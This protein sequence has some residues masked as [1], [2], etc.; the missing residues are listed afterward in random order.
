MEVSLVLN[1]SKEDFF[2]FLYS[3]IIK[4]IKESTGRMLS[5]KKVVKGYTYEKNVKNHKGKLINM[6]ILIA[7]LDP[8][9]EYMAEIET[10]QGKNIMSYSIKHLEAEKINVTYKEEYI[11][12]STF[13]KLKF[14]VLN[15][16]HEKSLISEA[17]SNLIDIET[18]IKN[19]KA[20]M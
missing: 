19:S 16:M 11:A 10:K 5:K 18:Y 17:K 6:K 4:D 7:E 15:L 13:K 2:E 20:E 8:Y 14:N 1:V 9:K 12:P 3:S